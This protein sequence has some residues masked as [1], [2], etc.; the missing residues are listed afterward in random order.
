M[1][2]FGSDTISTGAGTDV[3][4]GDHG[5]VDLNLPRHRNFTSIFILA[6]DGGAG[7]VI[8]GD[9]GDDFIIGG[10]GSDTLYGDA[11]EDDIIGGHNVAGGADAGDVISG[12]GEADLIA[13]DNAVITRQVDA[14]G[15]YLRYVAALQTGQGLNLE[16]NAV[17]RAFNLLDLDTIGGNDQIHGDAGDDIILAGLGDD[18]VYGDDGNDQITG[19]LGADMIDGGA[20]DDGI[21][22]DKG[23]MV[24]DV[25]DGS[26]D[27][28]LKVNGLKVDER[29]EVK[30]TVKY[31]V[32]LVDDT[33]GSADV[34][35]GGSGNDV[36]HAG[37]GN[38]QVYGDDG[39][40]AIFGDIGND[41][42]NGG[43]GDDH[44]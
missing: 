38:D 36:I 43:A 3:A 13:G 44:I 9:A 17:I 29:V 32:T 18:T 7:D 42:I 26:G 1:G 15:N 10:Q 12:G 39:N 5:Q 31:T 24:A 16:N 21:I 28:I 6:Q 4:F 35:Y 8:H 33:Q 23:T 34:V 19:H 37:T 20:G 14:S 25:L 2:G 40:D 30:G 27:R 41:A 11:D 22:A